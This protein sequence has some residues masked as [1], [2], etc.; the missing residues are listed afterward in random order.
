MLSLSGSVLQVGVTSQ[1]RDRLG[2]QSLKVQVG[3]WA[4]EQSPHLGGQLPNSQI[5]MEEAGSPD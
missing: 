5:K 2:R 1:G 4:R 3:T